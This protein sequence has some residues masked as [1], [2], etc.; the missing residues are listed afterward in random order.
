MCINHVIRNLQLIVNAKQ[1]LRHAVLFGPVLDQLSSWYGYP[2]SD[3]FMEII[4]GT[5]LD[6]PHASLSDGVML[7]QNSLVPFVELIIAPV[8][9][10][11]IGLS[12]AP[13]VPSSSPLSKACNSPNTMCSHTSDGKPHDDASTINISRTGNPSVGWHSIHSEIA[14]LTQPSQ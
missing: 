2:S 10:I 6:D 7:L 8:R 11:W 3:A 14:L 9:K 13:C 12:A 4:G 5:A 1:T